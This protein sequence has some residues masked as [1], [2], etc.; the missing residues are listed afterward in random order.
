LNEATRALRKEA[1]ELGREACFMTERGER[2]FA[3][4]DRLYFLKN[5]RDLGVMNGSLGTVA[6]IKKREILVLLD[7]GETRSKLIRVNLD[8]YNHLDH[9]YA[10]TLYKAQGVTV[11]RSYVLGS[12]YF[13][14]HSA[15][16]GMSRHRES[17]D[18]FWSREEFP[19]Y[20]S[21]IKTLSR[22]RSKD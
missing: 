5:D 13:D 10:A 15:Y 6:E 12:R 21:L 19:S 16:V 4:N 22:D 7:K 9:G 8:L 11:D 3:E 18:L 20:Q 1:G 2:L 17:V 14:A